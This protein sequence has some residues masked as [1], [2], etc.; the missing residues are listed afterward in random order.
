VNGI[1]VIGQSLGITLSMAAGP[2]LAAAIGWDVTLGLFGSA[3]VLGTLV[4]LLAG[5]MPA[6]VAADGNAVPSLPLQELAST[7]RERSTVLLSLGMMGAL[8]GNVAFGSWLP[9]YYHEQFGYSLERAGG[10]AALLALFGIAG[11]LL[12]STLPARFPR[13]RPFL[14]A[15]GVL[16]PLVALGTL[17]GASP[18]VMFPSVAL[19]GVL[20]WVFIPV[21]FTIPMELPRMNPARV[22]MAVAVFLTAGNLSG[23]VVPLLVGSLRDRTGALTL[24]LVGAAVLPIALAAAGY[25]MPETGRTIDRTRPEDRT[26]RSFE[27]PVPDA[28]RSNSPS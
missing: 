18:L 11:A 22:G 10:I 14:I 21:V 17:L 24:G 20:S 12:G 16:L 6:P 2:R 25:L 9:T 23:F 3:T 19:F 8:G 5:R 1:N 7:L 15:A 13:R 28:D 4:W 26:R 27:A